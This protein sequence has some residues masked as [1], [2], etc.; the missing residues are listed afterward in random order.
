MQELNILKY[1]SNQLGNSSFFELVLQTLA[2]SKSYDVRLMC[3][4]LLG[5]VQRLQLEYIVGLV[6]LL[7]YAYYTNCCGARGQELL[8]DSECPADLLQLC[9]G[10]FAALQLEATLQQ[11]QCEIALF[12]QRIE[13]QTLIASAHY[14]AYGDLL[15]SEQLPC[16]HIISRQKLCEAISQNW[17]TLAESS[18]AM[19]RLQRR[20]ASQ[21]DQLQSQRSNWNRN[22]IDSLLRNEQ[23]Q[24]QLTSDQLDVINELSKCA[25]ALC[26]ME[27]VGLVAGQQQK[28]LLDNM[29]QWLQAHHQWQVCNARISAVEQAIV[30]LLDPEGA[31]DQCWVENV[32]GLLEDYTC[33]VQRELS[34]LELEQQS[35]HRY[36][37]TLLKEIQ[38]NRVTISI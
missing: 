38:V 32:Q 19:Q 30:Q 8:A 37:C 24:H 25:S 21:L 16:G 17:Q 28:L 13:T 4:P 36:I 6:P 3:G 5:F 18:L 34:T 12:N 1:A 35:R 10:L 22:H 33:K 2:A 31:I 29:E 23:L 20:L 26:S 14:W 9:D 7:S 15:D 27:Q 11:Q